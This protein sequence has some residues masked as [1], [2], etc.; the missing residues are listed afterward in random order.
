M[1]IDSITAEIFRGILEHERPADALYMCHAVAL[2]RFAQ[3]RSPNQFY[4]GDDPEVSRYEEMLRSAGLVLCPIFDPVKH[5][6]LFEY[7]ENM[8]QTRLGY[9]GIAD[10]PLLQLEFGMRA[11]TLRSTG[12]FNS[13]QRAA[14]LN[15]WSA[16][17]RAQPL[18]VG[19]G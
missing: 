3:P 1:S 16:L 17:R 14:D 10:Q 8:T 5:G 2:L 13:L 19:I 9:A 18:T 6:E 4:F 11:T 7:A 12:A 15:L